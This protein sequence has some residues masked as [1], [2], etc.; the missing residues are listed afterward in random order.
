M[1]PITI[2]FWC[3]AI[4]LLML[5]LEIVFTVVPWILEGIWLV[6]CGLRDMILKFVNRR[7]KR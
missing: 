3:A 4:I 2:I 5:T 1:I 7:T 6:V